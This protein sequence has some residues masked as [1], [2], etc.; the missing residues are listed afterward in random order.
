MTIRAIIISIIALCLMIYGIIPF[1][2][3]MNK[4][5]LNI[6]TQE[7]VYI[8]EREDIKYYYIKGS[9]N[10][11]QNKFKMLIIN[12]DFAYGEYI[13]KVNSEEKTFKI[14]YFKAHSAG[15]KNSKEITKP[16]IYKLEGLTLKVY[17]K[18][19]IIQ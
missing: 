16:G 8:G 2:V 3:Y 10:A 17:E 9:Y 12:R 11:E 4:N 13:V 7:K 19:Q 6:L 1:S 15:N 18:A 14:E 5:P